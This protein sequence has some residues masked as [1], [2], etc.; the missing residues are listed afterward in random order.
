MAVSLFWY[1]AWLSPTIAWG[2]L[3]IPAAVLGLASACIWAPLANTATRNLP[4]QFAG[5]GSG[6]YNTTRQIG[7]VLGS[8][9]IAALLS[10]RLTANGLTGG[11][12]NESST[13]HL[14]S[15]IQSPFSDAMAQTLLL[16]A[17]IALIGAVVVLF[18]A[19]P[20]VTTQWNRP[21]STGGAVQESAD[22]VPSHS[23]EGAVVDAPVAHHTEP[24]HRA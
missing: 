18:F 22:A 2:W 1:S 7:A 10:A 3:L 4:P 13:T 5:A 9:S 19:K 17:A 8:A 24:S 12:A 15:F 23:A 21:A 11:G 16:P 6:V 14:P 20:S